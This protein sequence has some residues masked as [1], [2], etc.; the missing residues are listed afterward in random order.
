MLAPRETRH[1]KAPPQEKQREIST[2]C[3]T[4]ASIGRACRVLLA[5]TVLLSAACSTKPQRQAG[6]TAVLRFEN[7][8]GDAEFRWA[9]RAAAEIVARE[10]GALARTAA[11]PGPSGQRAQAIAGGAARIVTGAVAKAGNRLRLDVWTEHSASGAR[12]SVF[13]T[14][15][16]TAGIAPL[17]HA[18]ARK[19]DGAEETFPQTD[20]GTLRDYFL[21]LDAATP[22]EASAA[23]GRAA[24]GDP[25]FGPA[26][27]AW[28]EI[29]LVR[30]ERGSAAK[31]LERASAHAGSFTALDKARLAVV[32]AQS[33]N[34]G[35]AALRALDALSKITRDDPLVWR[36]LGDLAMNMKDPR[37]AAAAY[38]RVT[39]LQPA[40]PQSRNSLGYAR[41]ASGDFEGALKA[42]Q[43]YRQLRPN[44][45]NAFDSLGDVYYRFGKFAEAEKAY[46]DGQAPGKAV[47]ARLM[48]GDVMGA[49]QIFSRLMDAAR[50]ANDPAAEL[51]L[52]SWEFDTGRRDKGLARL[53]NFAVAAERSSQRDLSSIAYSQLTLWN[54]ML[55]N[56]AR[57]EQ[58]AR[59]AA[60]TASN[61][62]TAHIAAICAVLAAVK[63]LPM[64]PSALAQASGYGLLLSRQFAAAVPVL[65]SINSRAV[66]S[67]DN[68]TPVMLAWAQLASGQ[69][70]DAASLLSL[71]PVP[72]VSRPNPF[73]VFT[74]PRIVFLRAQAAELAGRPDE[75]LRQY[76]LF[77]ALSGATPLVF[78]EE[79][80]ARQKLR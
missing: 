53:E 52:G 65:K 60:A 26:W 1:A 70:G 41:T 44:D 50:A 64:N 67:P 9:E 21:G 59:K 25:K 22:Q 40:E 75:A 80:V 45:A 39:E 63:G 71:T 47:F 6:W 74:F 2:D 18:A 68:D 54:L 76:R 56:G 46:L 17:A 43:E 66:L 61:Q 73:H 34:D 79:N 10:I 29:E 32:A 57:A 15:D 16:A 30:G 58:A 55:G 51:R 31:I 28:T 14:G 11:A 72:Q 19:M 7:L 27:I 48:T 24:S 37:A 23:L 38:T 12:E 20:A 36:S 77:V 62:G 33:V 49:D 78:G 35:P 3:P 69:P 42:M 8:T 13:A 5:V 4:S